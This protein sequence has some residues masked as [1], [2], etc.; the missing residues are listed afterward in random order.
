MI[1]V[2]SQ[3]HA[4]IRRIRGLGHSAYVTGGSVRDTQLNR[5]PRDWDVAT[6]ASGE[7]IARSFP[8]VNPVGLRHNTV[9]VFYDGLWFEVTTYRD[10]DVSLAGDLALRDFTINAMAL[11]VETGKVIDPLGGAADLTGGRLRACVNAEARFKEDPLRILRAARFM[12]ELSLTPDESIS[13]AAA[14]LKESMLLPAVERVREEWLK[15]IVGP[16]VRDAL[17]WLEQTGVMPVLFPAFSAS[18][19]VG[20]NRWHRWDVFQHTVETVARSAARPEVRLAAMFHDLGKPATKQWRGDDW[21]FY[22]HERISAEIASV[23]LD[24]LRFGHDQRDKVVSLVAHHMFHYEE[25][26]TDAAVRR[27]LRR[28]S[29]ELIEPLFELRRA[30]SSATGMGGE[31]ETDRNLEAF[32][33]RIEQEL[34]AHSAFRIKD[35]AINGHDVIRLAGSGGTVVGMVLKAMLERVLDDPTLNQKEK[36]LTEA[37]LF[38]KTRLK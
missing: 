10:P 4:V 30:D 37:E 33:Q 1:E 23:D 27:F 31:A 21:T 7:L 19:G 17:L 9:G 11:D 32:R 24:R 8:K 13:A 2:P 36:L 14:L 22:N 12:S 38:L 34:R 28:V 3:V 26:W 6:S 35:L 15:L 29:P 18:R 16:S 20:Q 25:N 5:A